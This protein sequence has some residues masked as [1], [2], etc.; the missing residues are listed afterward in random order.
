MNQPPGSSQGLLTLLGQDITTV[1]RNDRIG[2]SQE[3]NF[4]IQRELPG[5]FMVDV[6]YAGSKGNKLPVDIHLN[7]LPDRYLSLGSALLDQVDNPF[8]GLV[9]VG[10][11]SQRRVTRGQL[12]RPFPEFTNVNVRAVHEGNSIYHSM[13]MKVERRFSRGFSLLASYTVS[14]C[15]PT[16]ARDSLSTS[17]AP[18]FRTA[19]ISAANARRATSISRSAWC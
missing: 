5:N 16:P 19:T 2:Y 15:S 4:N 11:L 10:A 12:L 17:R 6:A 14:N 7:Q 1:Y 18:A 13:Q 8:F 9:S 3:W